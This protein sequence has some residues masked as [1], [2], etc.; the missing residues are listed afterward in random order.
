ME[1]HR[2]RSR[3]VTGI[4]FKARNTCMIHAA[5]GDGMKVKEIVKLDLL[6]P[7]DYETFIL[8]LDHMLI[9]VGG[10]ACGPI[11][12]RAAENLGHKSIGEN[13]DVSLFDGQLKYLA[14]ENSYKKCKRVFV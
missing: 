13:D 9:F 2:G 11:S 14:Q 5:N 3:L 12:F 8:T 6:F 1:S 4:D 7:S 10:S